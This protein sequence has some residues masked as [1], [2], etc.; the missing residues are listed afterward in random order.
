M[1]EADSNHTTKLRSESITDDSRGRSTLTSRTAMNMII[2]TAI[3]G[4]A[5]ASQ[6][7][8]AADDPILALIE[9]HREAACK[10]AAACT[11]QSRREKILIDD[12][13]GLCPFVVMV[14]EGR[15]MICHSHKQIDGYADFGE[16]ARAKAHTELDATLAH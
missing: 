2:G 5:I 9:N 8:A 10:F 4:T 3:A 7:A 11:E 12:G 14:W 15:P 16:T 1:P 13:T 6:P